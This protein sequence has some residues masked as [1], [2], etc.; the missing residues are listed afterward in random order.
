MK[1]RWRFFICVILL[2]AFGWLPLFGQS[3]ADPVKWSGSV[4]SRFEICDWFKGRA[5]SN[6]AYSGSTLR[7]GAG[8]QIKTLDWQLE[9]TVPVLLGLP[10]DAIAPG[11][12]GQLGLGATYFAATSG[13]RNRAL[14]FPKQAFLRIKNL[15]GQGKRSL[16]VGRFEFADGTETTPADAT[17]AAVKRERVAQRLLGTF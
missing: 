15:G 10:A 7:L 6:Y 9:M 16:R 3:G 1:L 11:T 5:D 8:R 2:I 17:L 12:Q 14:P 13:S 4:R